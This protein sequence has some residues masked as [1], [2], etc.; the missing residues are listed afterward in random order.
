ML[1][2]FCAMPCGA[3]EAAAWDS[4]VTGHTSITRLGTIDYEVGYS[5][6][7]SA[8]ISLLKSWLQME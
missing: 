4:K 7:E 1:L 8:T 2:S 6:A 3:Q 5:N